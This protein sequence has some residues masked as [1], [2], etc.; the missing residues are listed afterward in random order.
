MAF[1]PVHAA[2][3]AG[4]ARKLAALLGEPNVTATQADNAGV[5]PLHLAASMQQ[6]AM[7]LVNGLLHLHLAAY[8]VLQQTTALLSHAS[9]NADKC[10][11]VFQEAG[12]RRESKPCRLWCYWS[13][14][15]KLGCPAATAQ[16]H[17]TSARHQRY[18]VVTNSSYVVL[19]CFCCRR[20]IVLAPV[21]HGHFTLA[22]SSTTP[23]CAFMRCSRQAP[24]GLCSLLA[25]VAE[26]QASEG[27]SGKGEPSSAQPPPPGTTA[28]SIASL[29]AACGLVPREVELL[30]VGMCF[31]NW[32]TVQAW[33]ELRDG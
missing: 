24:A 12:L 16:H 9:C 25:E 33:T 3:L 17:W 20:R 2:V 27:F 8:F 22:S 13:M 7:E 4:D 30:Q 21:G 15:P 28:A 18:L 26:L 32:H 29:H 11:A 31:N 23:Y 6:H 1:Y 14:T 10:L 5:T 19:C